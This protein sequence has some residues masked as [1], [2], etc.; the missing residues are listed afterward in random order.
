VADPDRVLL[1][2]TRIRDGRRLRWSLVAG[3][4]AAL[5][6]APLIWRIR[7][8][9]GVDLEG[10]VRAAPRRAGDVARRL[11]A[12]RH[13]VCKHH[14][15]ILDAVADGLDDGD[16][17]LGVW[18]APRLER[19]LLQLQTY[20]MELEAIGRESGLRLNLRGRDP[21][22]QPLLAATGE[23]TAMLPSLTQGADHRQSA[24]LRR[25]AALVR[26]ASM[27][28]GRMLHSFSLTAIDRQ[29]VEG[30]FA[31]VAD[32]LS[33]VD[34]LRFVIEVEGSVLVRADPGDLR[35]IL[36]NLLRN[37]AQATLAAGGAEVG[38][39]VCRDADD[40]TGLEWVALRI[41]DRSPVKLTTAR[42]RGRFLGRGLGLAMDLVTRAGG[43][44]HVEAEPGWS[45][46]V[47]VRLPVVEGLEDL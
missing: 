46:A 19:A 5:L 21:A 34:A 22:F 32:E 33:T 14:L 6:A 31:G 45:K 42:L 3:G 15:G 1:L 41:L 25:I 24:A 29:L 18:A 9:G 30:A 26:D 2:E 44:V 13:E 17:S 16:P 37:A 47:V 8:R 4:G 43:S 35:D 23:L 10:L 27:A 39:R 11:A 38:L 36:V 7:R 20:V 12:I 28:I 40:I